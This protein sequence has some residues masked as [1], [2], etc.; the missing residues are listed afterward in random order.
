[1]IELSTLPATVQ[2]LL[3]VGVILFEAVFLYVGYGAIEKVAGP[4]IK[5][6][7]TRGE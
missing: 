6:A 7:I 5:R 2:A 4:R 1:M 3:F